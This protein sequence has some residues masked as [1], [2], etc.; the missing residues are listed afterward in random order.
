MQVF[1]I[2]GSLVDD[3]GKVYSSSNSYAT[4]PGRLSYNTT[5]YWRVRVWDQDNMTSTWAVGPSFTTPK[6]AYP[7]P[8]FTWSPEKPT[9]G[10]IVQFTD[11]SQAY[12]GA[13]VTFW[14]WTFQDG[15]PST[16]NLQ[17]PQVKFLSPGV[18]TVTLRVTDSDGY[19]CTGQK[20]VNAQYP[21]P[22]WKEIHPGS[23]L[24]KF[25]AFVKLIK[26]SLGGNFSGLK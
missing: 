10:E 24:K 26:G 9:I 12:G 22:F 16:S 6:H 11:R 5:Y 8:D 14:Y 19:S 1:T 13:R 7:T 17:N 3:S 4:P 2:Y 23:W 18:K 25:L 15:D 21:L 20:R